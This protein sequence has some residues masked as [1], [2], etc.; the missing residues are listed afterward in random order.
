[1]HTIKVSDDL[2]LEAWPSGGKGDRSLVRLRSLDQERD[3]ETPPGVVVIWPA[4]IRP[5][6]Q[7]LGEAAAVLVEMMFR[8]DDGLGLS[9]E[10]V[11]RRYVMQLLGHDSDQWEDS[12]YFGDLDRAAEMA[13]L[14]VETNPQVKA[15]RVFDQ[16]TGQVVGDVE[17]NDQ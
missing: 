16:E 4:E 8:E 9:T 12:A 1:M 5:L 2:V 15:G 14:E 3:G 11:R 17:G 6:I 10:R 13:R 7:G